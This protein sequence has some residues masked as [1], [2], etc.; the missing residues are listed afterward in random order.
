MFPKSGRNQRVK[1]T[2]FVDTGTFVFKE[3]TMAKTAGVKTCF[4]SALRL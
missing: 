1:L 4:Y 3:P 2:G